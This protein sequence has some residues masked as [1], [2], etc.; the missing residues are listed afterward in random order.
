MCE[1]VCVHSNSQHYHSAHQRVGH[2]FHFHKEG[3]DYISYGTSLEW[4]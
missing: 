3:M 1:I 4:V 2:D